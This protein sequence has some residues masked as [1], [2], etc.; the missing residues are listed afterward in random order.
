MDKYNHEED[1]LLSR[2]ERHKESYDKVYGN[3]IDIKEKLPVSDN[4][5]YIDINDLRELTTRDEYK[6]SKIKEEEY[7][8]EVKKEEEN[9]IYDINE[10]IKKA[11]DEKDKL[12]QSR[13]K[14]ID[15][16]YLTKISSSSV[17]DNIEQEIR[18]ELEN[19]DKEIEEVKKEIEPALDL[20]EDLKGGDDTIVTEPINKD[21]EENK[22]NNVKLEREF[23]S[24]AI[25]FNDD[26]FS[27]I[28][29]LNEKGSSVVFKI[30]I[31]LLV[32]GIVSLAVYYVVENI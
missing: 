19:L 25:S 12:V 27:D 11:H 26:D 28:E 9:R 29:D 24:G 23:Y 5:N 22:I 15:Y 3:N 4:F 6:K 17:K 8:E 18:N 1:V 10:L 7:Q 2:G 30:L 32:I 16:S 31:I 21:E 20:F 14:V 13:E